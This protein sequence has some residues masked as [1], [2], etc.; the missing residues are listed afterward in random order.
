MWGSASAA[1]GEARSVKKTNSSFPHVDGKK[2]LL[3]TKNAHR[4]STGRQVDRRY[5][6]TT[7]GSWDVAGSAVAERRSAVAATARVRAGRSE[8]ALR[9][10]RRAFRASP[11]LAR[12]PRSFAAP[13]SDGSRVRFPSQDKKKERRVKEKDFAAPRIDTAS[14]SSRRCGGTAGHRR[15]REPS[16]RRG[17]GGLRCRT[18]SRASRP[19]R[20]ANPSG[21]RKST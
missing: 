12:A 16:G 5:R 19:V 14:A 8:P 3:K 11:R 17:S 6:L 20:A 1:T 18:T 21:A 4:K 15:R 2:I 7:R 13:P 9:P 10:C